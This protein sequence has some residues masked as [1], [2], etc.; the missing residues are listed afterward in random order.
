[1][2]KKF[3][4]TM[5]MVIVMLTA[6]VGMA[7]SATLTPEIHLN[8]LENTVWGD[9]YDWHITMYMSMPEYEY[10]RLEINV[11]F[12][13]N[14]WQNYNDGVA[15]LYNANTGEFIYEI[16]GNVSYDVDCSSKDLETVRSIMMD[17]IANYNFEADAERGV[18]YYSIW[19]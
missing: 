17:Y 19:F 7:E 1:M 18:R 11:S 14:E 8:D 15:T 12:N 13:D 4:A 5:F 2:M 16:D 9:D 3:V 10:V 6:A